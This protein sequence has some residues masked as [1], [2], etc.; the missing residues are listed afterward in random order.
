MKKV[1]K[2][3]NMGLRSICERKCIVDYKA[4][5]DQAVTEEVC[6]SKISDY[7]DFF[8]E[9]VLHMALSENWT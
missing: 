6:E 4:W 7:G 1:N 2:Q 5:R 3:T 9:Y 8:W